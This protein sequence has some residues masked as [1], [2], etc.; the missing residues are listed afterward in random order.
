[1][2]LR[3]PTIGLNLH[4]C[5]SG[6]DPDALVRVAAINSDGTEKELFHTATFPKVSNP[7]VRS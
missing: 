3:D 4:S 1:M 7:Q 2:A 5:N 6:S